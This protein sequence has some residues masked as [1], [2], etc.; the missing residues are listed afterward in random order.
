MVTNWRTVRSPST[1]TMTCASDLFGDRRLM[2]M[3]ADSTTGQFG[4]STVQF[5]RCLAVYQTD[6]STA[7]IMART[8]PESTLRGC[9][10][11]HISS[12][13]TQYSKCKSIKWLN[14]T[15]ISCFAIYFLVRWSSSTEYYAIAYKPKFICLLDR[16]TWVAHW[17]QGIVSQTE[18]IP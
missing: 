4:R 8:T 2:L 12:F 15:K 11:G 1:T 6:T 18:R 5:Y 3:I 13:F 7:S 14:E 10:D 16:S 9:E 17:K